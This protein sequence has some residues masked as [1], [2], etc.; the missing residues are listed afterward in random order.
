M[1]YS[2]ARYLGLLIGATVMLSACAGRSQQSSITGSLAPTM[3]IERFLRAANQNDLDTMAGLFGTR[4][5]AVTRTW[6]RKEIDDR[7]FLFASLLRHSD[8]TV[9][10]EQ[11]VPGRRDEATQ[12]TVRMVL[13]HGPV[14][15]PFTMV[16]TR[17]DQWLIEEIGIEAITHPNR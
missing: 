1:R 17:N 10:S 4:D 2:G 6:S 5:G 9:A 16:R 11:I 13:Q 12:F 14:P 7:M 3:T 15:V 8:Y